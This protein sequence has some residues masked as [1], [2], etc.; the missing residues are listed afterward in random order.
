M[1]TAPK[2]TSYLGLRTLIYGLIL[3]IAGVWF[4]LQWNTWFGYPISAVGLS[5]MMIGGVTQLLQTTEPAES[6]K[7]D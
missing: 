4:G 7:I 5:A 1:T 6:D 3:F 2:P